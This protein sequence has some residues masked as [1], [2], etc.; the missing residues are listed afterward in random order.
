MSKGGGEVMRKMIMD[1]M[2]EKRDDN[3]QTSNGLMTIFFPAQ[4]G[5]DGFIDEYGNSIIEDPAEPIKNSEG[6]LVEIGAETFLINKRRTL[7]LEGNEQGLIAQMQDFPMSLKECFM[8]SA[9]NSFMPV[10]DINKRLAT[11]VTQP[12]LTKRGF[13]EWVDEQRFGK[14]RFVED[15][16]GIYDVSW[17]QVPEKRNIKQLQ[18]HYVTGDMCYHPNWQTMDYLTLGVDSAQYSSK[19]VQGKKKS[20]HAMALYYKHDPSV[21]K[22]DG[23]FQKPREEWV[24]EGFV[25]TMK[26]RDMDAYQ[27]AEECL[28]VA[29]FYGAMVYPE[30][31]VKDV[32]MKFNEWKF[33][34]YM[35]Y[36]VNEHGEAAKLPGYIVSDGAANTT[37]QDAIA[38][39]ERYIRSNVKYERHRD[40]L[41]D[42]KEISGPEEMTKFDMFAAGCA[43]LR[44]TRSNYVQE[45]ESQQEIYTFVEPMFNEYSYD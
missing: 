33:G 17:L 40:I 38:G 20:F 23:G 16:A 22:I 7:E 15:K 8:G 27:F 36:D 32:Y 25:L 34:G 3:G 24:S 4:D 45:V 41:H 30:M 28:K 35:K 44:G 11:L 37:K 26:T 43:A 2:W 21:D 39:M 5:L 14:V 12:H 1:G 13:F 42:C 31:N 6:V 9:K 18:E 10:L 29:I 19:E